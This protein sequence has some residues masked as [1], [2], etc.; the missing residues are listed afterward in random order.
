MDALICHIRTQCSWLS[1]ATLNDSCVSYD[2]PLWLRAGVAGV[3]ASEQRPVVLVSPF[4]QHSARWTALVCAL[5]SFRSGFNARV[6]AFCGGEPDIGARVVIQPENKFFFYQGTNPDGQVVLR[7]ADGNQLTMRLS[8]LRIRTE[9]AG[10]TPGKIN[11]LRRHPSSH[12][13]AELLACDPLGNHAIL[14]D[15]VVVIDS[16]S[17]AKDFASRA[18]VSKHGQTG[19]LHDFD[20][21][22]H[23]LK[24]YRT[25]LDF[26]DSN[27][28]EGRTV[29]VNGARR[30]ETLAE[31]HKLVG[32]HRLVIF[33]TRDE[34]AY[35]KR[36]EGNAD[37]WFL[38]DDPWLMVGTDETSL[39]CTHLAHGDWSPR[40][41]TNRLIESATSQL[42]KFCTL[43]D[44]ADDSPGQGLRGPAWG[45]LLEAASRTRGYSEN[46]RRAFSAQLDQFSK[47]ICI[48]IQSLTPEMHQCVDEAIRLLA[49][50]ASVQGATNSKGILLHELVQ[51]EQRTAIITRTENEAVSVRGRFL[52]MGQS[53]D[54]LALSELPLSGCYDF[55]IVC[56]WLGARAMAQL[57]L[58]GAARRITLIG[59]PFE[60]AWL[61]SLTSRL[62]RREGIAG[63][64]ANDK[65][66]IVAAPESL[67]DWPDPHRPPAIIWPT[68][69]A[70]IEAADES[71][72]AVWNGIDIWNFEYR[73]AH[74]RKEPL[75]DTHGPQSPIDLVPVRYVSFKGTGYTF[76]TTDRSVPIITELLREGA[77]AIKPRR[78]LELQAGDLVVF[79]KFGGS[80][81]IT[82]VA[83]KLLHGRADGLRIRA[84][85]YALQLRSSHLT[86]DQFRSRAQGHGLT[87]SLATVRDWFAGSR[88][89]GPDTD[90]DIEIIQRVVG[91]TTWA[92]QCIEARHEL[93]QAHAA[94]ESRIREALLQKLANSLDQIEA[95][96]CQLEL[97]ELGSVWVQCVESVSEQDEVQ[98]KSKTNRLLGVE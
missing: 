59:Y 8:R 67:S 70:V 27:P 43:L 83:D 41:A 34:L 64:N 78:V 10:G 62:A 11:S 74:Q 46:Q 39:R 35:L 96:G 45:L 1:D 58:S 97:G 19:I 84:N 75:L 47:A 20:P 54:V 51:G 14:G 36:L 3:T 57:Y 21:K 33:A 76:F 7:C 29:I 90:E 61:K 23:L 38:E 22:W 25:A 49:E 32:P 91:G 12:L 60:L 80:D 15:G 4:T 65:L 81:L 24:V 26:I 68:S 17:G 86:P 55:V 9:A 71:S 48:A 63:A 30:L 52:N 79:P 92:S 95:C 44:K 28:A 56:G 5:E 16:K 94:A 72:E 82:D 85:Q 40:L 98:P 13:F 69:I 87:R 93:R 6:S 88:I 77:K 18:C 50:L 66:D 31:L 89:I 53:L 73:I 42:C 37:F 2:V